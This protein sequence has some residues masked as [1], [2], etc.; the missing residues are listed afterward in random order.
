MIEAAYV[1]EPSIRKE[2]DKE[3]NESE[4]KESQG[5]NSINATS[6]CLP[7][8]FAKRTRPNEREDI[9][10]EKFYPLQKTVV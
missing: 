3:S 9:E 7:R 1:I 10:E 8:P 4:E 5:K 6:G 2:L